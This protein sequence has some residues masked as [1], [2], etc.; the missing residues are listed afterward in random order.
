[1]RFSVF[2]APLV[3]TFAVCFASAEQ[4]NLRRLKSADTKLTG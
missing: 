2:L 1:M 3:A 4:N